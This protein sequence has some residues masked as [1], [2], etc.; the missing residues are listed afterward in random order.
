[1]SNLKNSWKNTGTELGHAFRDL[2]KTLINSGKKA[3]TK[4]LTGQNPDSR[5]SL[6]NS[7]RSKDL[8]CSNP[9]SKDLPFNSPYSKDLPFS[10]GSMRSLRQM[11][12]SQ[13]KSASLPS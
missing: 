11:L 12:L 9:Y 10:K 4:L 2:G 5:S 7:P 6:F 1:M 13:M 8:P 3:L